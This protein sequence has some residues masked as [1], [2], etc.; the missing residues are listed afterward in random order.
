MKGGE[1]AN[2]LQQQILCQT[3]LVVY[4]ISLI[5]HIRYFVPFSMG[6]EEFRQNFTSI[7]NSI[8]CGKSV[9]KRN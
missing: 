2:P 4:V 8:S 1:G 5:G 6:F 9:V 3:A 7:K